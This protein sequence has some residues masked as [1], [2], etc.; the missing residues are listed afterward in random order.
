MPW[1]SFVPPAVAAVMGTVMGPVAIAVAGITGHG[2]RCRPMALVGH[3]PEG[4]LDKI[5]GKP[6]PDKPPKGK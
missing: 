1:T 3:D 5:L 4:K 6:C 2:G